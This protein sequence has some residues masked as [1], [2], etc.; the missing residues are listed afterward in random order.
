MRADDMQAG[1]L[2]F[3]MLAQILQNSHIKVGEELWK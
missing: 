3:L 2:S 1:D